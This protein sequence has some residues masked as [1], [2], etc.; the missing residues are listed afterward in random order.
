MKTRPCLVA[1]T[2]V[3]FMFVARSGWSLNPIQE[4]QLLLASDSPSTFGISVSLDGDFALVG[5]STQGS[6]GAAYVF[7]KDGNGDWNQ[8]AKLVSSDGENFDDFGFA[9]SLSGDT[10]L[11][12][13]L[14]HDGMLSNIGAAYIF[15]RPGGGWSGTLNETAK[16]IASDGDEGFDGDLFG[17]S[18][19]IDGT[20][21]L[22][23]AQGTNPIATQSGAV[24]VFERP[25]GGWASAVP[26]TEDDKLTND[27]GGSFHN[28]GAS[29]AL[30]GSVAVIGA[31][32][33]RNTSNQQAGAA[34]V[35]EKVGG[36]FI[37]KAK[38]LASDGATSSELGSSVSVSDDTVVAGA[39]RHSDPDVG[40]LG[41]AGSAYIFVRPPGGW[42][43]AAPQTEAVKLIPS[44][45]VNAGVF[46]T[47]VS[48]DQDIA[49]V[50]SPTLNG[51]VAGSAYVYEKPPGGWV[52][53]SPLTEDAKA[54]ADDSEVD[55]RFG[56]SVSVQGDFALVG[57]WNKSVSDD[58]AYLFYLFGPDD[59]DGDGVTDDIDNCVNDPNPLQQDLDGDGI[60]TVCDVC[61][62]DPTNA[63]V[64][65]GSIGVEIGAASGGT[66][67]TPDGA[68]TLEFEPGDLG[69]DETI[70]VTQFPGFDPAVNVV[71]VGGTGLGW[72]VQLY[73]FEPDGLDFSPETVTLTMILN[74]SSFSPRQRS[75]ANLYIENDSG[76]FD[77]LDAVCAEN[78]DPPGTFFISCVVEIEHFTEFAMV[79][80]AD[81]DGDGVFDDFDGEVDNCPNR[82]NPEQ[83]DT[84]NDGIGDH[85]D[86][87]HLPLF[88]GFE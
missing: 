37:Q 45:P 48:L 58:A 14:G 78:E 86:P 13:A 23:G 87:D 73:D 66:V 34:Y 35:F 43:N 17:R 10:A 69:M 60:G 5:D 85:C 52:S 80:P 33:A 83:L 53:A 25:V 54:V 65:D 81:T 47:S 84:D 1:F 67:T 12:G 56:E 8:V 61:P 38:L 74:V 49:V 39:R 79:V 3:L 32:F 21:A 57:A 44:D 51:A 2:A 30:D 70:S 77:L 76:G 16:L 64:Q 29:V 63:C 22:I 4:D 6:V 75:F 68:V 31:V 59:T 46:G 55:D 36:N 15:V 42:S 11:V 50:G 41:A 19:A 20:T 88:D 72:V 24:Y 27:D 18:V 82:P 40:S 9:V 28:F 71:L 26:L 7:E 62:A